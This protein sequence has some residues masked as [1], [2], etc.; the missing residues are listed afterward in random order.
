M[1]FNGA[2]LAWFYK[3]KVNSPGPLIANVI[4][5]KCDEAL[6]P[7]MPPF[8]QDLLALLSELDPRTI[9]DGFIA[10]D[11][12]F[13]SD[14]RSSYADLVEIAYDL[15]DAGARKSAL[16]LIRY[17]GE[18]GAITVLNDMRIADKNHEIRS[19]AFELQAGMMADRSIEEAKAH[20]G[21]VKAY[22][23]ERLER[24]FPDSRFDH[25]SG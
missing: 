21:G 6:K 10:G 16:W 11:A 3:W 17:L 12:A 15:D 5:L 1:R 19:L 9:V 22:I 2:G 13:L 4:R 8:N 14:A 18:P 25:E 24:E 23:R 7:H 20:P